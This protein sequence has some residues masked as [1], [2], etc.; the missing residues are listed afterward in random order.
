MR[1]LTGLLMFTALM[2]VGCS[3]GIGMDAKECFDKG[4]MLLEEE[5]NRNKAYKF[6][7]AA[8]KKAPDSAQYHW[9]AVQTADNPNAAYV[10]AEA[11]WRNGLKNP[12]VLFAN[13]NLQFNTDSAQRLSNALLMYED[14]PDSFK[15]PAFRGDLFFRFNAYDSA[16][17]YWSLVRDQSPSLRRKIA[18]SYVG[19]KK[20]NTAKSLLQKWARQKQIDEFG[21]ILLASLYAQTYNYDSLQAVFELARKNEMYSDVVQLE[22]GIYS[23]A[24]GKFKDAEEKLLPLSKPSNFHR[25]KS[26]EPQSRFYLGY[27]Y[28]TTGRKDDLDALIKRVPQGEKPYYKVLTTVTEKGSLL[29]TLQKL[30]AKVKSHPVVKMY[31]AR[32]YGAA[33]DYEQAIKHYQQ[34]PISLLRSP[35]VMSEMA[36]A[37]AMSGK[38][39]EAL[40]AVSIMHENNVFTKTS[41]ELFRDLSWKKDMIDR[42]EAA[43][44]L[45]KQRYPDDAMTMWRGAIMDLR[46]GNVEQAHQ[47]FNTLAERYPKEHSFE[48]ARLSTYLVKRQYEKALEECNKSRAPAHVTAAVKAQALRSMGRKKEAR[49]AYEQGLKSQKTPQLMLRYADVLMGDKDYSAAIQTYEQL[50]EM[51]EIKKGSPKGNPTIMNN[52]AWAMAQEGSRLD[53]AIKLARTASELAPKSP[54]ILDTYATALMKAE[55]FGQVVSLLS[56]SELIKGEA[57][58]LFHLAT[59][60]E[61]SGNQDK[62]VETYQRADQLMDR[63]SVLSMPISREA[64]QKHVE[65]LGD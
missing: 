17:A 24:H 21:Y 50:Q 51:E 30:P 27:V 57:R 14:L 7:V 45:L 2:V 34:L 47:V 20:I 33:K 55:K 8:S 43:Q 54:H 41:L 61:K 44:K 38:E 16:R 29:D 62:A 49:Q 11:A 5:N 48:T 19:E 1:Q 18:A 58:L 36:T 53:E 46:K 37:L 52:L 15:T 28:V 60:Y 26:V 6:F 56:S 65:G 35:K 42:A 9:A 32:A 12:A 59:A 13:V 22:D 64:L 63:K 39:D 40:H 4:V 10:H 25:N 3:A 23:L 31:S